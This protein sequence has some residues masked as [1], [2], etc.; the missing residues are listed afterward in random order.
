MTTA[1]NPRSRR[2]VRVGGFTFDEATQELFADGRP[3]PLQPKPT[4][5]LAELVASRGS[6]VTRERLYEAAWGDTVVEFDLALNRCVRDIRAAVGD[7]ARAPGFVA[8]V[9]RR[10][11][12]LVPPVVEIDPPTRPGRHRRL[13]VG[14][15][16]TIVVALALSVGG[17]MRQTADPAPTVLAF[18]SFGPQV[19]GI[20]RAIE[21]Q[22]RRR[23]GLGDVEPRS[24][25]LLVQGVIVPAPEGA[26]LEVSL[27]RIADGREIWT[28]RY[29]PL[30]ERIVGDPNEL[31]GA[32]VSREVM[33]RS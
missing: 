1:P 32:L 18:R 33:A 27:I 5:V 14:A 30:C 26:L 8:T 11:Y 17:T 23:L 10:G 12:R 16:A 28:G 24:H 31:I 21:A 3:V 7:D 2:L 13:A 4:R 20:D 25:G 19:A 15:V 9:P 29:N 22:V 6:L